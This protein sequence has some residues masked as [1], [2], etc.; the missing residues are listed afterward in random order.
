MDKSVYL[1]LTSAVSNELHVKNKPSNF[2]NKIYKRYNV[3]ENWEVAL[4]EIII[5]NTVCNIRHGETAWV[6]YDGMLRERVIL[7]NMF[8]TNVEDLLSILS[9]GLNNTYTI[10]MQNNN[11]ICTPSVEF[12]DA[13]IRFTSTLAQQLGLP[14]QQD[15]FL[16]GIQGIRSPDIYFGINDRVNVCSNLVK[17][18]VYGDHAKKLLRT[19]HIKTYDYR[20]GETILYEFKNPRYLPI[21]V[22]ELDNI[23]INITGCQ[24]DLIP[25]ASGQVTAV[26][27]VRQ[28]Y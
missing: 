6:H 22:R 8:V 2:A 14:V 25:F 27:H 1:T 20:Y 21:A 5:P 12:E 16:G 17:D 10:K 7:P 26:V 24:G 19:V 11:V 9:R 4:T 28:K 15:Y 23:E 3:D 13:R 18:Q